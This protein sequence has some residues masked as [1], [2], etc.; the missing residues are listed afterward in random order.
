V[1]REGEVEFE[2]EMWERERV[3]GGGGG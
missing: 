2:V 3:T 1:K